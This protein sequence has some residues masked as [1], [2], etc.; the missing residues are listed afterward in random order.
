MTLPTGPFLDPEAVPADRHRRAARAV[1]VDAGRVLLERVSVRPHPEQGSWWELPG[2]GVEAGETTAQAAAREL[3]EET[4]YDDVEVG[5]AIA[6]AR[7]R[8]RGVTTIAEQHTTYHVARLRSPRRCAPRLE[9]HEAAGLHEVVW[10]TP[11]EVSDGRR[12]DVPELP[13]LVRDALA[14]RLVPRRLTDRDVVGWSDRSPLGEPLEGGADA[15]LVADRVVRDAAPWTEAVHHWLE[16]LHDLGIDAVPHPIGV[17][18]HGREAVSF[19]PGETSGERWPAPLRTV[20]GMA[21]IGSLLAR[22]REAAR[23]FRVPAGAVWRTGPGTLTPGAVVAHGDVGHANLVW[24]A[25][26]SPALI[27]WEFAHPAPPLRDLALAAAWLAPLVDFD[28]ERWGFDAEPDRRARLH[29][30]ARAGG[31]PVGDLLDEVAEM[32]AWERAR[33]VELGGLG[34]RPFDTYLQAGQVAGFDRL[35]G[36]LGA[37]ATSLR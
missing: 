35:S 31:A 23:T 13:M 19:V 37:H 25:D 33:V 4:G 10:L 32:A 16:H 11:D 24:R 36:Y 5:P 1:L 2:G 7:I 3:A 15:H 27:D 12:L 26:G 9:D 20:D 30:L 34:I 29:A 8:Y 17:D 14:G 6:T 18:P 21:A 28:H 22:I